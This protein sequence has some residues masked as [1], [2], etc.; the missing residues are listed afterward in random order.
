VGR[1]GAENKGERTDLEHRQ[2]SLT[3]SHPSDFGLDRDTIHRCK[4]EPETCPEG[5]SGT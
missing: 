5:P 1:A 4:D 2:G 3:K